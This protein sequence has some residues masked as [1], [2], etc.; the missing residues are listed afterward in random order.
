M[1]DINIAVLELWS[2]NSVL[3]GDISALLTCQQKTLCRP[4]GLERLSDAGAIKMSALTG[5]CCN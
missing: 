5:L 2:I 1:G 3:P 4:P